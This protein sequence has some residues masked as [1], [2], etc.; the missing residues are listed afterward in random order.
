MDIFPVG[1]K[2][3]CAAI[4]SVQSSFIS[5]C[6]VC[7]HLSFQTFKF[8]SEIC[9]FW[10]TGNI[11]ITSSPHRLVHTYLVDECVITFPTGSLSFRLRWLRKITAHRGPEDWV[12]LWISEDDQEISEYE[13]TISKGGTKPTGN[14]ISS[15][16][17][18]GIKIILTHTHTNFEMHLISSRWNVLAS[19]KLL[20]VLFSMRFKN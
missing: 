2:C 19:A 1:M 11:V 13:Q 3:T 20:Q 17:L 5:A 14:Y 10:K 9:S 15:F 6:K 8:Y 18:R 12:D 16:S 7:I 4:A